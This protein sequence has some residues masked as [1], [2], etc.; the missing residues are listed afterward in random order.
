VYASAAVLRF[1]AGSGSLAKLQTAATNRSNQKPSVAKLVGSCRPCGP[2]TASA[3][4]ARANAVPCLLASIYSLN[5][6]GVH[7]KFN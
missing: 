7:I 4:R 1:E 6:L 3:A 2:E 5:H